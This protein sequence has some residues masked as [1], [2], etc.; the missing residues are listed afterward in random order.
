MQ[1]TY[2]GFLTHADAQIGRVIEFLRATGELDNTIVMVMSDNGASAEGGSMG[3]FNEHRFTV[4]MPETVERSLQYADDW[5]GPDTYSHYSW[6]WAWAGN[7]PFHLWKRY[8]WLGGT[9]SP[10]I[11]HWPNG[12]SDAGAV[13][14]QVTHIVDILPTVLDACGVPAT[15]TLN[16][17]PQEALD[18][19][20]LVRSFTDQAAPSP[21]DVQYFEMLGSRSIISGE[22]KATTDHVSKGVA[23][24]ERLLVGSRDFATDTWALF[25][26]DDDFTETVDVAAEHPEVVAE[27]A[28][29]WDSEALRNGVAPM[30]DDLRAEGVELLAPPYPANRQ[31]TYRPDSSPASDDL[32]P[33]LGFGGRITVV[34]EMSAAAP[35]GVCDGV[36]CQIGDWNGG[37]ALLVQEGRLAAT[38]ANA[39]EPSRVVAPH[40]LSAGHHDV[41]AVFRRGAAGSTMSLVVDGEEVASV[42]LPFG[43]PFLWQHGGTR[44]SIGRGRGLP[45]DHTYRNPSAFAGTVRSVRF[46]NSSEAVRPTAEL[47]AE[48][49]HAE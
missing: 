34:M 22:W 7:S 36:L 26:L 27:L 46:D 25:R 5:G 20:S 8:S 28:A 47:I 37:F 2:A 49:L 13:R 44:L 18:G 42:A 45:V 6:G 48:A 19:G 23:D 14:T 10:L 17:V 40:A 16:G 41:G 30:K 24:E 12:I 31:M 4:R 39:G 15:D 43:M 33:S 11:V 21:R 3:T 35:T 38:L 1:E 9:R 32:M 29:L